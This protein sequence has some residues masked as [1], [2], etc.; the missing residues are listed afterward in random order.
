MMKL[1]I[2]LSYY[3]IYVQQFVVAFY[4][5]GECQWLIC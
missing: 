3:F 4:F 5:V 2:C 1:V